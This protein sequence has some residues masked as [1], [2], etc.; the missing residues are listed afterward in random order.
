MSSRNPPSVKV[1]ATILLIGFIAGVGAGYLASQLIL[2]E[3]RAQLTSLRSE[4]LTL[5]KENER[6]QSELSKIT[7]ELGQKLAEETDRSSLLMQ[8]LSEA[9]EIIADLQGKLEALRGNQSR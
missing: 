3:L 8:E 4:A 7:D 5:E 9:K 2:G 6:L 1:T